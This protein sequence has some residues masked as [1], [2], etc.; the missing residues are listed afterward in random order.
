M[1][2]RLVICEGPAMALAWRPRLKKAI[3]AQHL[4]MKQVSTRAGLNA[5]AVQQIL[6]GKEPKAATLLSILE[7]LQLS[8]D[9]LMTGVAPV[10]NPKSV[11]VVGETAAGLWLEPDAWDEAKYPPVPFVPTRYADLGWWPNP[12]L[13]GLFCESQWPT[14]V[15]VLSL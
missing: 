3:E 8:F 13:S 1:E 12:E 7:V 14:L 6:A 10:K 15:S 4:D 9:E 11:A 5:A 2:S